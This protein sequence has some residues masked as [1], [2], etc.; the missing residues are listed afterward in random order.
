MKTCMS[1]SQHAKPNTEVFCFQIQGGDPTGTGTG[2]VTTA[3]YPRFN[4][5]TG[6]CSMIDAVCKYCCGQKQVKSVSKYTPRSHGRKVDTAV[7]ASVEKGCGQ[8]QLNAF[9]SVCVCIF[10]SFEYNRP[11]GLMRF[12]SC[13]LSLHRRREQDKVCFVSLGRTC[14]P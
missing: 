3:L 10:F 4:D 5:I 12:M 6:V 7:W 8:N 2:N 11:Q 14:R 13:P 9:P 1:S